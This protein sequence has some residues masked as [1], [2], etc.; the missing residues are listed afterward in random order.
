MPMPVQVKQYRYE[1]EDKMKDNAIPNRSET[2]THGTDKNAK[3]YQPEQRDKTE[4]HHSKSKP[5][6]NHHK[7]FI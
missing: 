2:L 6:N 5:G 1:I 7:P 4:M 3:R